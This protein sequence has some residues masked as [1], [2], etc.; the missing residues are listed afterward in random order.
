MKIRK[1]ASVVLLLIISVL[2]FSACGTNKVDKDAAEI[3][4]I[5]SVGQQIKLP[6]AARRVIVSNAYNA[7]LVNAAGAADTIIG[8]DY[9]IFQDQDGFNHR[10][11]KDMII[12]HDQNELN[13]E[14]IID[15][16]PDAVILTS[17]GSW[18]DADK[19][20]RPFNIPVIVVDA[21]YTNQFAANVKLLGKIFGKEDRAKELSDYFMDKLSYIQKKLQDV[22]RKRVYFEYRRKGQTT[23]PG[24]YFAPMLD[25]AHAENIFNDATSANIDPETIEERNPAYIVKVSNND[26]YSSYI[27]P[28]LVD[29]RQINNEL[30]SR[31]GWDEIDAVKN[32]NILLMSHY[33][34]GGA[35]KL[36]GTFYIAKF[37]YPEY[38]P[39]LDPEEIFKHWVTH[40][41]GLEYQKGHVYTARELQ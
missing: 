32:K 18:Q 10:F 21:Y 39:D 5:D 23:F 14:K 33:V 36:I 7:E 37:L 9:Y 34:H 3:E 31:S 8:V 16:A 24:D 6:H 41:Q 38:L 20:L 30:C 17:N 2:L 19:K 22:P 1:I 26:A 28:T 15:L 12:G 13:Y 11:T 27:P 40:F 25:L 4:I 29:F 35:S